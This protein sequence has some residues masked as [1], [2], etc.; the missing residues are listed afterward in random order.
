MN[1]HK[2]KYCFGILV[3]LGTLE[4]LNRLSEITK[5][6]DW[7]PRQPWEIAHCVPVT[8]TTVSST[9]K[10]F[11]IVQEIPGGTPT[12]IFIPLN[13]L[14]QVKAAH[15]LLRGDLENQPTFSFQIVSPFWGQWQNC[16]V[17]V[18]LEPHWLRVLVGCQLVM[19]TGNPQQPYLYLSIVCYR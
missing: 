8:T 2:Q 5:L 11:I 3:D 7:P 12:T 4:I 10:I 15:G 18:K 17:H 19:G 1:S 16:F 6:L 9:N 14:L 13:C